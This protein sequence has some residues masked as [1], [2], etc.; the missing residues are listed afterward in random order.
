MPSKHKGRRRLNG[1]TRP[2]LLRKTTRCILPTLPP[3]LLL[4]IF[5]DHEAITLDNAIISRALLPHTLSALASG[6]DLLDIDTFTSFCLAL[7]R[8]PYL[9]DAVERLQLVFT[10]GFFPDSDDDY[11]DESEYSDLDRIKS[12][13]GI[14]KSSGGDHWVVDPERESAGQ[15]GGSRRDL[16]A[17]TDP[18]DDELCFGPYLV[19]DLCRL[20]HRVTD[21]RVCGVQAYRD[22]FVAP[23][24]EERPFPRLRTLALFAR[25]RGVDDEVFAPQ[26]AALFANLRL[27]PTLRTVLVESGEAVALADN[28]LAVGGPAYLAPRSLALS[29]LHLVDFGRIGPAARALLSALRPGLATHLALLSCL[30][31]GPHTPI[32]GAQLSSLLRGGPPSWPQLDTLTLTVCACDAS[33]VGADAQP[34]HDL[35]PAA[36]TPSP[37]PSLARIAGHASCT[38]ATCPRAPPRLTPRAPVWPAG[39][40][41]QDVRDVLRLSARPDPLAVSPT[42]M[43][44]PKIRRSPGK[45]RPPQRRKMTRCI[46]PTLPPD[47]LLR[48]FRPAIS[49]KNV[50]LSKALLPHTL[51]ALAY[52]VQLWSL[53]ALTSFCCAVERRPFL[54]AAVEHIDLLVARPDDIDRDV[55]WWL[56]ASS[57]AGAGQLG[58]NRKELESRKNRPHVPDQLVVGPGLL[59]DLIR[60]LPRVRTLHVVGLEVYRILL[61][62]KFLEER[63]FPHL[64]GL[65]LGVDP[66]YVG[67]DL[68]EPDDYALFAN[69]SLI[70]TLRCVILETS[71]HDLPTS[72]L[73][74]DVATSLA[75]RSL[76]LPTLQ[77]LDFG[78][79]GPEASTL[80]SALRPGLTSLVVSCQSFYKSF[81]ADL[82]RLPPT[83]VTLSLTV[84]LKCPFYFAATGGKVD[85]PLLPV[86]LPNLQHLRLGGPLVSPSTF[87]N[88]IEHLADLRSLAFGTHADLDAAQLLAYLRRR[89][90]PSAPPSTLTV[91]QIDLCR[92]DPAT[93]TLAL[94]PGLV[95][96][97]AALHYTGPGSGSPFKVARAPNWPAALS[98]LD[99]RECA[100]TRCILPTLPP[101]LLQRMFREALTFDNFLLSKALLPHALAAL[102]NYTI[103]RGDDRLILF[104]VAVRRRPFLVDA[105]EELEVSLDTVSVLGDTRV[106]LGPDWSTQ[107]VAGQLGR[108]REE[109]EGRKDQRVDVDYFELSPS[110]VQDLC[111]LLPNLWRLRVYGVE[112]YE[113]LVDPQYLEQRPFRRL[114]ALEL[115]SRHIYA[116][117]DVY[118][119]QH[120]ALFRHLAL[121]PTLEHLVLDSSDAAELPSLDIGVDTST[122]VAPRSLSLQSITLD[123]F[124]LIGVELRA[125]F[126]AL[127]P[128]L[129]AVKI[130][131][132]DMYPGLVDDLVRLPSTVTNLSL[133]LGDDCPGFV[134]PESAPKFDSPLLPL[135]LPKL[136]HLHLHGPLVSSSTF[137]VVIHHLPDLHCLSLGAHADVD[138]AQ[139]ISLLRG[140]PPS[141]P[142]PHPRPVPVRLDPAA[143]WHSYHEPDDPPC[144][145]CGRG[146]GVVSWP[147]R[148]R[149]ADMRAVASVAGVKDI[150][151]RGTAVCAARL[152]GGDGAGGHR[153]PVAWARAG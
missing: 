110:L 12:S 119:P 72:R 29:E 8:R 86:A 101:D 93:D 33:P 75:P 46:L 148:L 45:A 121:L 5:R 77:V 26:D 62:R 89:T 2:P 112:T 14:L 109:L 150:D 126:S 90:A 141:Y 65:I 88:V 19:Q 27:I 68:R 21:L 38:C 7:R 41:A 59:R 107:P 85:D 92:C 131:A 82:I 30:R 40:S 106:F 116:G 81:D 15:L 47:L 152:C 123:N 124:S 120:R 143:G 54:A 104:C 111:R 117:L 79:L 67:E 36:R 22:L 9:V 134:E 83:V 3:D 115:L 64:H 144:T 98:E 113:V 58:K 61:A 24:L 129:T 108:D 49:L 18:V 73:N 52:S 17:R 6:V 94:D 4:R 96:R 69:L 153:C 48:I 28:A 16:E 1:K 23:F 37:N 133:T 128:G 20:L 44:S 149:L 102:A 55:D 127:R 66:D 137:P 122:S 130:S 135:A 80:F 60:L 57:T 35:A 103:L 71:A 63:P 78:R 32:P 31:L 139:L 42:S 118:E 25:S 142:P 146:L 97:S 100:R 140:G 125:V 136:Q 147:A 70:P 91:L 151:V 132:T 39:L 56:P 53:A 34:D 76:Y 114:R 51:A 145:D 10:S 87:P 105:V 95:R 138:G 13:G 11:D 43:P 74:L 84:G 99:A 50:A